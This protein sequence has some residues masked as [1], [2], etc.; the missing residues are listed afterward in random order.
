MR[1]E[2]ARWRPPAAEAPWRPP[3]SSSSWAVLVHTSRRVVRRA[4]S[5][6]SPGWPV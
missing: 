3:G 6:T 1:R 2:R 5:C 4:T